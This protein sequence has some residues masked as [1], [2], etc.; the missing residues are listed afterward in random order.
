MNLLLIPLVPGAE[1]RFES[2]TDFSSSCSVKGASKSINLLSRASPSGPLRRLA[3]ENERGRKLPEVSNEFATGMNDL[4]I[5]V[6][7]G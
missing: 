7:G 5:P 2:D 6:T 1:D 4:L 3:S